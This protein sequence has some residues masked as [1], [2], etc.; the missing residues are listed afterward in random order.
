MFSSPV[1]IKLSSGTF[2]TPEDLPLSLAGLKPTST[3]F[4]IFDPLKN[5]LKESNESNNESLSN[6]LKYDINLIPTKQEINDYL[7]QVDEIKT[8]TEKLVKK[9]K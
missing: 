5:K 2:P 1:N 8:R 9:L 4:S 6:F 7:D 3:L